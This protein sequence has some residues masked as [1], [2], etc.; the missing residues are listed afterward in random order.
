MLNFKKKEY[1]FCDFFCW[2]KFAGSK[3]RRAAGKYMRGFAPRKHP[4][5]GLQPGLHRKTT[6][7]FFSQQPS[8]RRQ[9]ASILKLAVI[10]FT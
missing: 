5:L 1:I 2:Q 4:A 10:F 8:F 6:F 3:T 9:P 7:C